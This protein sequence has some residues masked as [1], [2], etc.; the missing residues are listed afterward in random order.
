[1]SIIN[2]NSSNLR[3]VFMSFCSDILVQRDN[4]IKNG[5]KSP[6]SHDDNSKKNDYQ[7]LY[8]S[9][10]ILIKTILDE[11]RFSMHHSDKSDVIYAM[12]AF[13]DEVFLNMKWDGKS[14]WETS[15]LE[16]EFFNTQFAG[17]EIFRKF[18][19]LLKS[20][21]STLVEK[22]EIYLKILSLG[23]KGKYRGT[24]TEQIEIDMYR[25]KLFD[26]IS[27]HGGVSK[28]IDYRLFQKEYTYTIPTIHRKLLPDS[29][30]ITYMSAFF[31]FMFLTISSV[32]WILEVKDF[33]KLLSEISQIAMRK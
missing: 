6:D 24:E 31:V 23:F 26:F 4:I 11:E 28:F 8:D 33:E 29:S 15:M 21:S 7:A 1:M 27:R 5:V 20:N 10:K 9:F 22:A 2:L 12:V 30:I 13:A 19:A 17:E 25:K 18:D 14:F 32:V 16:S 3:N